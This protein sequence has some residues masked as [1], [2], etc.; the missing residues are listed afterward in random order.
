[1]IW[2]RFITNS[3]Y[4]FNE[5]RPQSVQMAPIINATYVDGEKKKTVGFALRTYVLY[6]PTRI[7]M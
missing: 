3:N 1:M 2:Q 4:V 7:F 5:R 6:L